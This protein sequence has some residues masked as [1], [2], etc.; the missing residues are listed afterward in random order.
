MSPFIQLAATLIII[1]FAAKAAGLIAQK[2]GQPSVLGELLVGIILGPTL[3]DITHLPFATDTHLTEI[4]IELGEM[5]VLF[6]MFLAGMELHMKEMAGHFKVSAFSGI[7]GVIFPVLLGWGTG[8]LFNMENSAALFLGLTMGATSVSISVQTLMELKVLRSKVGL[9]LLGAAV[10]DDILVIIM[11]SIFLALISGGNGLIEVLIIFSKIL[12]FLG[13]SMTVGLW[14]LPKLAHW[15]ARLPVSQGLLTM[16]ITIMLIY[17]IGAEIIG[18]MA[19]ITGTFIAGLMFSRSPEKSRFEPGL[20]AIAYGFFV[21]IFFISIGIS[22]NLREVQVNALWL[23][24]A[25]SLVGILG[26][27]V[28][29]G[30]GAKIAG[31]SWLESIQLGAGMISRGEVGLIV[32][33]VGLAEGLV[34][35]NEFS[36]IIG[37]VLI[38]TII[39]PPLLK[40][41]FPNTPAQKQKTLIDN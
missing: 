12:L 10:F 38:T 36:A 8:L 34:T 22:V 9:G 14:L 4:I 37:M 35:N 13:L 39:T 3:L 21:P 23:L 27:W 11:L 7:L 31:F 26:K 40:S 17:G 20:M 1:L 15:V 5:G 25:I 18:G 29:S 30:L 32:G 19:A 24:L 41:L 6:I 28:G 33:A 16:A 2:L